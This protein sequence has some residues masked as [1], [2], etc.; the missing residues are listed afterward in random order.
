M[1]PLPIPRVNELT[2]VLPELIDGRRRVNHE[3]GSDRGYKVLRG[4]EGAAKVQRLPHDF[5]VRSRQHG[6]RANLNPGPKVSVLEGDPHRRQP[7]TEQLEA[8]SVSRGQ[9]P[10]A[11]HEAESLELLDPAVAGCDRNP[12]SAAQFQRGHGLF[13]G[14]HQDP[15]GIFVHHRLAQLQ[16]QHGVQSPRS[17]RMRE[18]GLRTS[19]A[20]NG[21]FTY[22]IAPRPTPSTSLKVSPNA[23]IRIARRWGFMRRADSINSTPLGP[24]MR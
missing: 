5:A 3:R 1:N 13:E 2:Y 19:A 22:P 12:E 16:R 6:G 20:C 7:R 23:V 9:L 8:L 18:T 4:H 10:L 17:A 14:P 21:F 24:G 15:G 11:I